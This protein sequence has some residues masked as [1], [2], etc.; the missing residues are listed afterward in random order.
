MTKVRFCM[1][2]SFGLSSVRNAHPLPSKAPRPES[3]PMPCHDVHAGRFC[4]SA[5]MML[6]KWFSDVQ[7]DKSSCRT[8][9]KVFQVEL[10]AR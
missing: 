4:R 7:S 5:S 2:I 8:V 6:G 1:D 10:V 3:I 9:P